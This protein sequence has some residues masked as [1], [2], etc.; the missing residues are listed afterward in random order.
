MTPDAT[1]CMAAL[2][3]T[4]PAA[5]VWHSGGW[6]LRDGAGGGKRVAAASPGDGARA[7]D[8]AALMPGGALAMLRPDQ[9]TMD[10]ALDALGYQ[11]LD[12]TLLY[13]APVADI[14]QAPPH[15]SLFD[16]WPPLAIMHDIWA[17]G[18][19]GPAR[20]A[21]MDRA[22]GVKTAFVAR[23]ADRAVG[24]GFCAIHDGIAMLHAVEIAPQHRRKGAARIMLHGAA[25]WA[26][27]Q[28]AE[29]LALAVTEANVP[30]RH[31]Y[32]KAGL[33]Q[34]TRYHYRQQPARA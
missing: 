28:G 7:Q 27:A 26:Q 14:A 32:E 11:L 1:A 30:A 13:A 25:H 21:V 29:W 3:A 9:M 24:C 15:V 17:D 2:H 4:W 23:V 12:P 20:L 19:I 10:A 16:I 8:L 5:R 33:R 22:Q 18:G 31:L 34:V 6:T